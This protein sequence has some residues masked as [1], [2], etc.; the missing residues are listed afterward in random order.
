MYTCASAQTGFTKVQTTKQVQTSN[1]WCYNNVTYLTN[2]KVA[3]SLQCNIQA[4]IE[5]FAKK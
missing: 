2:L 4:K 1:I 5:N 3:N